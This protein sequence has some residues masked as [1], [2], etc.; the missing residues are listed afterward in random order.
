M[1]GPILPVIFAIVVAAVFF[2]NSYGDHAEAKSPTSGW[3]AK[4]PSERSSPSDLEIGGDLAS[5]PVGSTRY[6]TREELLS[7]PQV[8]FSVA[9]DPNFAGPTEVSGVLLETLAREIAGS[10]D[11]DLAVAICADQ[12]R[13]HY[14]RAYVQEHRPVLVL[15][16]NGQSP[17]HWPK[18][19]EGH[20]LDM[21]PYMISHRNFKPA[22]RILAH[23]DESQIPW[24][25]VRIEFRDEKKVLDA[26]APRGASDVV[27]KVQD[28]YRIAQQNCFRC[29]NMN[30]EGGRKAHRPWPVLAAWASSSPDYFASYVRHPKSQ[31]PN[32]QMTPNPKYDDVTLQ[33][34]VAYFRTFAH[35]E[36]P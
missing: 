21:G 12:Y 4:A 35:E 8:S 17:E 1:R 28:G 11:S 14:P 15:K 16:V 25:V 10:P 9:N 33:A 20:G 18:D 6:L 7:L 32:A 27:A 31:N 26:I 34:L 5:L 19:A 24:G 3:L 36:K 30:N 23:E 2:L 29:H 22:F 13:G